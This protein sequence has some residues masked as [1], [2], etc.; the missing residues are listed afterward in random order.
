MLMDIL[1]LDQEL[2]S[3][4][5]RPCYLI[6]GEERHLA[7][8]AKKHILK[9]IFKEGAVSPDVFSAAKS[10][11]AKIIDALKTPSMLTPWRCVVVEEADEFDKKDWEAFK[12]FSIPPKATLILIA[13]K[14]TATVLGKLG[15]QVSVVECKNLYPRQVA[16]WINMTAR[17][18]GVPISQEAA[19]FLVDCVGTDLGTLSQTLEML[20]LYVGSRKI[21]Q[22]ED[23]EV[24]AARSAQKNVF[25]LTNAMGGKNPAQATKCLETI[26]DQ[27]EEPLRILG[28]IARHFRLLATAQ[29]ILAG[30]GGQMG[31][32]FSKKLGVHP[33]F[34]K[35]YVAQAKRWKSNR[36]GK[37]F[38]ALFECDSALKSSRH[39]PRA[40]L[41][42]FIWEL[43][44]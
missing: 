5:I 22:L 31:P 17:D 15:P 25:E 20:L 39:E 27:G 26:L 40:V 21:I 38:E 19:S 29:E 14:L 34:A 7:L 6:V 32:D 41:E 28:M 16:G 9:T 36:W 43:C 4:K 37:C 11:L 3:D 35:D 13:E 10:S 42:K 18:L 23:V 8:T 30:S 12:N 1:T 24:V 2:R 44:C 33:F